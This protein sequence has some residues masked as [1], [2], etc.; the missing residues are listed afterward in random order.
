MTDNSMSTHLRNLAARAAILAV[1][2]ERVHD[3]V[4][5][6]SDD[7]TQRLQHPLAEAASMIRRAA[8]DVEGSARNLVLIEHGP[9]CGVDW[10]ACPE[11]G[12]TVVSASGQSWCRVAGC[13]RRW[14]YDRLSGH[15]DEP[16]AFIVSDQGQ[17]GVLM[18]TGHT[19]DAQNHP[20]VRI[21]P[22]AA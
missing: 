10:G 20:G 2:V 17:P 13:G 18:C 15:C 19:V 12:S 9:S 21:A 6:A 7:A 3:L 16:V 8:V 4:A 11:H 5:G 1:D 14:D 22:A